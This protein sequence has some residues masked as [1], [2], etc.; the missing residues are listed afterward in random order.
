MINNITE[1]LFL[2]DNSR[3][4]L[5]PLFARLSDDDFYDFFTNAFL[6]RYEKFDRSYDPAKGTSKL[7]FL[8]HILRRDMLTQIGREQSRKR[9]IISREDPDQKI[10]EEVMLGDLAQL[11][12]DLNI[13][14]NAMQNYIPDHLVRAKIGKG[15]ISPQE[16][17]KRR[18]EQIMNQNELPILKRR[19]WVSE[20]SIDEQNF[21]T[22]IE[23][24]FSVKKMEDIYQFDDPMP[25]I[26]IKTWLAC[27]K[28]S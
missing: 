23:N 26:R 18:N 12:T 17:K 11:I 2:Y 25:L 5:R 19:V 4:V 9:I 21:T 1:Y 3:E 6:D 28:L 27:S 24:T 14:E 10:A 20:T 13:E 7:T 16:L 15:L 22:L 8:V